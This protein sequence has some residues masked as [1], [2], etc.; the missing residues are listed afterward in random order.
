MSRKKSRAKT[1]FIMLLLTYVVAG[2]FSS[3]DFSGR[4]SNMFCGLLTCV[5]VYFCFYLAIKCIAV[6]LLIERSKNWHC[7]CV[8]R[9]TA[10]QVMLAWA[11]LMGLT[12][13]LK[14][15]SVYDIFIDHWIEAPWAYHAQ[16]WAY[17]A[18]NSTTVILCWVVT[19]T[20]MEKYKCAQRPRVFIS[21]KS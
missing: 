1:V 5:V 6:A 13:S 2:L 17:L 14:V 20:F 19:N 7:S 16:S 10:K 15:W 11:F 3:F 4:T 8:C 21:S 18:Q 9:D 12:G